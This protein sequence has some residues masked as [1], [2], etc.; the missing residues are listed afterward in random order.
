MREK[1]GPET[2]PGGQ[3]V[4]STGARGL[5]QHLQHGLFLQQLQD[6]GNRTQPK[7]FW[8]QETQLMES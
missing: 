5:C 1:P 3:L 4:P 8:L 2:Q 7:H 6:E